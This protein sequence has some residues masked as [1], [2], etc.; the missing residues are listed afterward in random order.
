MKLLMISTDRLIF[1]QSSLVALR[2][3]E[4]AK[5]LEEL[6]II[7]FDLA[8]NSNPLTL[9]LSKNCQVYSTVSFFKL[10]Y[11]YDAIRLGKSVI[12]NSGITN[13]TCQDPFLTAISGL[14]LK[15]KFNL[16]LEIQLHT[17][18]GSPYYAYKFSNKIRKILAKRFLPKA[19]HIR[20]VSEIIKD[21]LVNRFRI[22]DSKIEVRPVQVN[23][24]KI[25][26]LPIIDEAN[27]HKKYSQFNKIVL[28]VSRLEPEKDISLAINAWSKVIEKYPKAGLVIVGEGSLRQKLIMEAK[29]KIERKDSIVFESWASQ[30]TLASYYKTAD[31]FLNTSFF[32]GYG[33][34]LVE[35]NAAGCKIISTDVGVAKDVSAIIVEHEVDSVYR[36]I[37]R[38]LI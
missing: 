26:N 12:K 2:M 11:F 30:E 32:E 24:E 16:P 10:S 28:M 17:D 25:K 37:I 29:K 22:A 34:T 21:Y 18:I 4:Y 31:I 3:I 6:H 9:S 19:D 23:I 8:K 5:N 35:A 14:S 1:K 27:L 7:I 33:M 38:E 20:V 13:I 15:K 36:A